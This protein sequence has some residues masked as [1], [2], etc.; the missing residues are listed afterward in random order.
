MKGVSDGIVVNSLNFMH[1]LKVGPTATPHTKP[2]II[3]VKVKA[4][5]GH[6]LAEM[7]DLLLG[8]RCLP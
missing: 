5:L 2:I 1:D 3:I 8:E 6:F 4:Q 7:S